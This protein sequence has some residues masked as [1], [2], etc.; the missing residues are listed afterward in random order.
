MAQWEQRTAAVENLEVGTPYSKSAVAH[1]LG[2]PPPKNS[3]DWG[4]LVSFANA[5]LLFITLE[6]DPARY[7]AE[8]LYDDRFVGG[9]LYWD[10]RA[11]HDKQSA[12]VVRVRR[13]PHVLGFA[14]IREKA[15]G[16]T[17]PFHFV[18]QLLFDDWWGQR[19]VRFTWRLKDYPKGLQGSP[20]LEAIASWT[21]PSPGSGG[22]ATPVTR[23]GERAGAKGVRPTT[24]AGTEGARTQVL[25]NRYERDPRARR[26]CLDHH[27]TVCNVCDFDFEAK[28]G[29]IGTGFVFVHHRVPVAFRA[30]DGTYELDPKRDLVPLCGNCHAVVHRRGSASESMPGLTREQTVRL[31]ELRT[32]ASVSDWEAV[33]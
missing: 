23:P 16:R 32:L 15:R 1:A 7:A 11:S 12:H 5:E 2:V 28:Y 8:H 24:R 13:S 30:R 20:E 19:P 10:S 22:S 4:G 18:G 29:D 3:R 27:G 31:L 6:K 26:E 9:L 33:E 17:L 21:P 14:R 25:A